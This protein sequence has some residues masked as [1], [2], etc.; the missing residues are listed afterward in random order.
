[1]GLLG[2]AYNRAQMKTLLLVTAIV[3]GCAG[4]AGAQTLKY[5]P[6]VVRLTGT[7]VTGEGLGLNDER[8][9]VDKKVSFPAIRLKTPVRVEADPKDDL[10]VESEDN[11]SMV[12]LI[13]GNAAQM[14]QY[15]SLKGKAVVVTGTL[16]HQIT[17]QHYTKVLL[18]VQTIEPLH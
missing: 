7:F 15:A 16:S 10:N 1:M 11:V 2:F 4:A 5:E 8:T 14:K 13:I 9:D 18:D 12:Q 17:A 3:A 6:A